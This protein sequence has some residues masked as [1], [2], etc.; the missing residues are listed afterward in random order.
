MSAGVEAHNVDQHL[1]PRYRRP[2]TATALSKAALPAARPRGVIDP[3]L[4]D[5]MAVWGWEFPP[6]YKKKES[7]SDAR[8]N[9][10][11]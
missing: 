3:R 8:E 10:N 1:Q 7:A 9:S 4:V 5:Q 2:I 6:D 11:T